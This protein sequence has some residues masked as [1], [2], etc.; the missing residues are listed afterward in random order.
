MSSALLNHQLVIPE[1]VIP[2][3][4]HDLLIMPNEVMARNTD[5]GGARAHDVA[6]AIGA[7]VLMY[8]REFGSSGLQESF[9]EREKLAENPDEV[10]ARTAEQLRL[11]V[12]GFDS[13]RWNTVN[14]AGHS[15]AG[16][17]AVGVVAAKAFEV[18]H[19]FVTDPPAIVKQRF[20]AEITSYLKYT[21][22]DEARKPKH[23]NTEYENSEATI[24]P[25]GLTMAK[26]I[27]PELIAYGRAGRTELILEKL[28]AIARDRE[29]VDLT[30]FF[31]G[32]TF[33]ASEVQ[34]QGVREAILE[35]AVVPEGRKV[36]VRVFPSRY[37]SYFNDF[38][39]FGQLIDR[40]IYS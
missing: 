21:V 16:F 37:H 19:L 17:E 5:Y 10:F 20:G 31:P 1:V 36:D 25:S 39:M 29:K 13:D 27:I 22:F 11:I 33:T 15:A 3:R 9:S 14:I 4:E 40:A 34:L 35:A 2:G 12:F 26:R 28:I 23:Q 8:E 7:P 38:T 32:N 24:S 30:A 6:N 18:G